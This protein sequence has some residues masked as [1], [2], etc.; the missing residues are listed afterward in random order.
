LYEQGVFTHETAAKFVL[1]KRQIKDDPEWIADQ[2]AA[3]AIERVSY[4]H[5]FFLF[6]FVSP[7]I[8]SSG[9]V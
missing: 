8:F 2:L 7:Y 5:L 9:I 1:E 6:V 4:W 3:E